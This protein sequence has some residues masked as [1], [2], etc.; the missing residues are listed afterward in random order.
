MFKNRTYSSGVLLMFLVG[1]VLYGSLVLLPLLLQTLMGYSPL[2]AGIALAPRGMGSFI[3]MPLVGIVMSRVD[4]RK[5][6]VS[7]VLLSALTLFWFSWLNLDAGYWDLFWPQFIQGLALGL[8]F[9][10]LTTITMDPIPN[11]QMGNATSLYNLT[12]NIGSSMG[13]ALAETLVARHLQIHTNILGAR[14]NA[15][16]KVPTLLF[17]RLKA[18]FMAAG[19]DAVTAGHQALGVLAG[20][21]RQQ[22]ALLAYLDAFRWLGWLTVVI[23][24]LVFL[25]R[26]PR[27]KAE[28]PVAM[29]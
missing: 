6:L 7:G 8:L 3:A 19:S 29:E 22:A 27:H 11:D 24:P 14:V 12:R 21:V 17:E 25:M 4:P 15:Y 28:G 13:I 2:A 16:D 9:V 10:P 23:L 18:G 5:L 26:R 20:M 1:F